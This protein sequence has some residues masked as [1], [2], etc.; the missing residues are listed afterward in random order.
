MKYVC[1]TKKL[2]R[3]YERKPSQNSTI[4]IM[5]FGTVQSPS[6]GNVVSKL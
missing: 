2:I 3:S 4:W 5:D 6:P 1:K